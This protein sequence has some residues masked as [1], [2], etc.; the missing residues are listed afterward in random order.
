MPMRLDS[1]TLAYRAAETRQVMGWLKAEPSSCRIRLRGA[2]TSNFLAF[3]Q[4]DD[5]RQYYLGQ[6]YADVAFV[7]IDL[8]ALVEQTEAAVYHL[9]LNRQPCQ[10]GSAGADPVIVAEIMR[11]H[12]Q[13]P[14]QRL[15]ER[16]LDTLCYRPRQRIVLLCK[17]FGAFFQNHPPSLFHYLRAIRDNQKDQLS[18]I[19][20][21]TKDLASLRAA[22][23][24][25]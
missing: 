8:L 1:Y 7:L 18:N 9:L 4:R 16:S 23:A 5:V 25:L 6:A 19:V 10:F 2:G 14:I 24:C 11:L 15:I 12:H 21:V 20:V 22:P 13:S 17:N 3:L